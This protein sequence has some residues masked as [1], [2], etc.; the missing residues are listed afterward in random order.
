MSS[1]S[2]FCGGIYEVCCFSTLITDLFVSVSYFLVKDCKNNSKNCHNAFKHDFPKNEH[3][4]RKWFDLCGISQL[5]NKKAKICRD[6]FQETDYFVYSNSPTAGCR[7]KPNCMPSRNLPTETK[8]LS[9]DA[10]TPDRCIS[11]DSYMS[12]I[13]IEELK[14]VAKNSSM[15]VLLDKRE[16]SGNGFSTNGDRP[17]SA[18]TDYIS[19]CAEKRRSNSRWG[20]GRT[21]I[22]SPKK[23]DLNNVV[24]CKELKMSDAK[25]PAKLPTVS[26]AIIL[27]MNSDPYKY[28][29]LSSSTIDLVEIIASNS[30]ISEINIILTFR[31][32]KLDED[33]SV[34]DDYFN[35]GEGEAKQLF[36]YT[37]SAIAKYMHTLVTLPSKYAIFEDIPV[38]SRRTLCQVRY[39]LSYFSIFIEE[40][41]DLLT[42]EVTYNGQNHCIHYFYLTTP[43][44]YISYVSPGYGGRI[45][46]DKLLPICKSLRE[47]LEDGFNVVDIVP[48]FKENTI[49]AEEN[50]TFEQKVASEALRKIRNFSLINNKKALEKDYLKTLDEIVVIVA[51]LVNLQAVKYEDAEE[52]ESKDD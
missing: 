9:R 43:D 1:L 33:F 38:S 44:G 29:G 49:N 11:E 46:P 51:A 36:Q 45:T 39:Y 16:L 27:L 30:S 52:K 47:I 7:L 26:Q 40:T 19:D 12:D 13:T 21:G 23:H 15:K 22:H 3:Q 8:T 42:N 5:K 10:E 6:H 48:D 20:H 50:L 34:L 4:K 2:W 32:I 24:P 18:N 41:N 28:L 35:L 14:K 17:G 25:P 31:K 37:V